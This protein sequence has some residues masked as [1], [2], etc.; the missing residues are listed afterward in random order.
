MRWTIYVKYGD[1]APVPLATTR[2]KERVNQ[3][4]QILRRTAKR[5]PHPMQVFAQA[6]R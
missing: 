1:A 5:L 3:A 6:S 2:R 4:I